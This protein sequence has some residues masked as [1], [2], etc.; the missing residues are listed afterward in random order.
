VGNTEPKDPEHE[1][2]L[3]NED[4]GPESV[5]TSGEPEP[6][7]IAEGEELILAQLDDNHDEGGLDVEAGVEGGLDITTMVDG[8]DPEEA[9]DDTRADASFEDGSSIDSTGEEDG[10]LEG[11]EGDPE[12]FSSEFSDAEDATDTD[13]GGIDGTDDPLHDGLD[14]DALPPLHDHEP[15]D[16]LVDEIEHDL[17]REIAHEA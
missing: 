16:T 3:P 6:Q 8:D 10:W 1:D 17:L 5:L 15:D 11:S 13:D 9:L 2:L 14:E 4:A 12:P 7:G